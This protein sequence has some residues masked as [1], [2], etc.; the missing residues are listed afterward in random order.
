L[1]INIKNKSMIEADFH[2][3]TKKKPKETV[4]KPIPKH[5]VLKPDESAEIKVV[6][7]A[8]EANK[9]MDTLHFVI[10][11]GTDVDVQLK[12]KGV[13]STIFFK[14]NLDD[15]NFGVLY[16]CRSVT[17]DIFV[18]NKGRKAQVLSWQ[19]K[20]ITQKSKETKKDGKKETESSNTEEENV[21]QIFPERV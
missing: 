5:G 15:I 3:F 11:E 19:K 7:N 8:D 20:K 16:T 18:E 13:G 12:A 2:V 1:S 6:C 17:R 21:F 4:F 9:F 10:R 14:D